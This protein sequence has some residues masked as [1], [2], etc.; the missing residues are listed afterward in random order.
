MKKT[1]KKQ[2]LRQQNSNINGHSLNLNERRDMIRVREICSISSRIQNLLIWPFRDPNRVAAN[3][4][5]LQSQALADA[6]QRRSS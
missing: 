1:S 6:Q 4:K 2:R 5:L 3:L